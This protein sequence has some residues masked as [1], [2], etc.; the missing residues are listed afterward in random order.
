MNIFSLSCMS[1]RAE[2]LLLV[3]RFESESCS[4]TTLLHTTFMFGLAKPL[5]LV[6]K[7]VVVLTQAFQNISEMHSRE[8]TE[9]TVEILKVIKLRSTEFFYPYLQN[10]DLHQYKLQPVFSWNSSG[11]AICQPSAI[12]SSGSHAEAVSTSWES[13]AVGWGR[14]NMRHIWIEHEKQLSLYTWKWLIIVWFSC[15][16]ILKNRLFRS[17]LLI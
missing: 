10:P 14:C 13:K 16:G 11:T 2:L 5:W 1:C 3:K 17:L 9:I 6:H 8:W 15:G 7:N 4:L 12:L